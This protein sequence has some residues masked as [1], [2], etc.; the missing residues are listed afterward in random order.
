MTF[1]KQPKTNQAMGISY[2]LMT[3]DTGL[4]LMLETGLTLFP[5]LHRFA[6]GYLHLTPSGSLALFAHLDL[7][8]HNEHHQTH[9]EY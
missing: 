8:P 5:G 2:N 4:V 6:R 1:Y 7:L 3:L 9:D